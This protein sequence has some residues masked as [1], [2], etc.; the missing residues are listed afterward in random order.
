MSHPNTSDLLRRSTEAKLLEYKKQLLY[1][2]ASTADRDTKSRLS[3][4]VQDLISGI[5]LLNIPNHL[6]W[7]LFIEGTDAATIGMFLPPTS[8]HTAL[9][10]HE[11][12]NMTSMFCSATYGC[13]RRHPSLNFYR[14]ILCMR[15][16]PG[17]ILQKMRRSQ[18]RMMLTTLLRSWYGPVPFSIT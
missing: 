1:A 3:A 7:S 8:L 13:S 16:S 12:R 2:L 10:L 9:I 4:E 11:K 14:H 15:I 5:V 18:P 6:A 17:V